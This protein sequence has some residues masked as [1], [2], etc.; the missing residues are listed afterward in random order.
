[1]GLPCRPVQC[2]I[3]GRQCVGTGDSM[4][5][6]T[7]KVKLEGVPGMEVA[8]LRAP[9]DVMGVFGT[10]ASTGTGDDQRLSLSLVVDANGWLPPEWS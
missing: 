8:A 4:S 1:M 3:F 7:F 5:K 10:R 6:L 9:F 2:Y